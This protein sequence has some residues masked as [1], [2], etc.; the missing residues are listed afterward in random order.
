MVTSP[1]PPPAPKR[2]GMNDYHV[3]QRK[4]SVG[5]REWEQ[6]LLL[7]EILSIYLLLA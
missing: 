5:S 6:A 4:I 3:C 1:A 2:R 7:D